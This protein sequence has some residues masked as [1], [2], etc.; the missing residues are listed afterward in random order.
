MA[1]LHGSVGGV[2]HGTVGFKVLDRGFVGGDINDQVFFELQGG[3]EFI[4]GSTYFGPS[5]HL[6]WVFH[7]NE[8][9]SLFALGGFGGLLGTGVTQFA[10]RFGVGAL[11][12]MEIVDIRAEMSHNWITAGVQFPF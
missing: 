12:H 6:R 11:Y 5:G 2:V 4:L 8:D 3:P 1:A 10:P 9:V 7:R